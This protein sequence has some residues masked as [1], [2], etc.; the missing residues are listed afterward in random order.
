MK[1]DIISLIGKRYA[2]QRGGCALSPSSHHLVAHAHQE[3]KRLGA[4]S[5]PGCLRLVSVELLGQTS[6][7]V[8]FRLPV[9]RKGGQLSTRAG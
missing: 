6:T 2:N 4:G 5:C 8:L 1:E 9:D 7:S 3:R